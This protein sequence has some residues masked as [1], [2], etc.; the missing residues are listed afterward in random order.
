MGG[1]LVTD[2]I[3]VNSIFI[4]VLVTKRLLSIHLDSVKAV[5]T[6]ATLTG[7][8]SVGPVFSRRYRSFTEPVKGMRMILIVIEHVECI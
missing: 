1:F 2:V 6:S 5:R 3:K 8:L 7:V 4:R